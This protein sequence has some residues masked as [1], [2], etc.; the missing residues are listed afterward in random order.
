MSRTFLT[1][2]QV[3]DIRLDRLV[4][5]QW[6]GAAVK[7]SLQSKKLAGSY[8]HL[9]CSNCR[10]PELY[11]YQVSGL[12]EPTICMSGREWLTNIHRVAGC[13]Q[14]VFAYELLN[15]CDDHPNC[16]CAPSSGCD[17]AWF[18][19]RGMITDLNVTERRVNVSEVSLSITVAPY[20]EAIDRIN[21]HYVEALASPFIMLQIPC[22]EDAAS[23]M[24]GCE[25]FDCSG[26]DPSRWQRQNYCDPNTVAYDPGLW[27]YWYGNL[28]PG[29]WA[30][31]GVGRAWHVASGTHVVTPSSS[32]FNAPPRS[33]YAFTDLPDYGQSFIHVT[34]QDEWGSVTVTTTLERGQT[35]TFLQQQGL[36]GLLPT[37]VVMIGDMPELP[38]LII[39]NGV[40]LAN[41]FPIVT[42]SDLW[43]GM[44]SPARNRIEIRS[45]G[46]VAFRHTFRRV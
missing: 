28:R 36:T 35:D 15:C 1:L 29:Y 45:D 26:C 11:Q 31:P 13:P 40:P 4:A 22:C 20:W 16:G 23:P 12:V 38:G 25:V 21:F 6:H 41:V 18:Q 34:R 37:D 33:L 32:V 42:Y 24:P 27:D 44:L 7:F 2:Y 14:D 46:L 30:A 17:L 9:L 39:R 43:P 8:R 3:G 19:A 10:Q 5:Q